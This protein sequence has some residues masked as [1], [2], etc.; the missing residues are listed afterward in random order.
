[1]KYTYHQTGLSVYRGI[2]G[3]QFHGISDLIAA[4]RDKQHPAVDST[5]GCNKHRVSASQ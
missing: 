5:G 1:M 4:L 2:S 3:A